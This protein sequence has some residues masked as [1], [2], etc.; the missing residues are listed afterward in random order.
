MRYERNLPASRF[1]ND[2]INRSDREAIRGWTKMLGVSESEILI[3]VAVVGPAAEDVRAYLSS[4]G[5]DPFRDDGHG[6]RGLPKF[7][8]TWVN[9]RNDL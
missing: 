7:D 1:E 4:C 3:A 5:D 8:L 9:P 2:H 6:R